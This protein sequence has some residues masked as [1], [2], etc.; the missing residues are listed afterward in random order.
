MIKSLLHKV[1]VPVFLPATLDS[2]EKILEAIELKNKIPSNPE[3]MEEPLSV[4]EE[5]PG[6][7][8]QAESADQKRRSFTTFSCKRCWSGLWLS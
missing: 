1:P 6:K 2:S 3:E 4:A 8:D 7:D 5:R